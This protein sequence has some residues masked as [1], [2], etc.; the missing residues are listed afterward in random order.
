MDPE[1]LFSD[2]QDLR[3]QLPDL[4]F[5]TKKLQNPTTTLANARALF[6]AVISKY[7]TVSTL[8]LQKG[9]RAAAVENPNFEAAFIKI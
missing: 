7:Q 6:D 9:V 1:D 5:I 3:K 2:V 8:P 4:A